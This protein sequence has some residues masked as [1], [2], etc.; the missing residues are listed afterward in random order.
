MW[1]SIY[2][3]SYSLHIFIYFNYYQMDSKVFTYKLVQSEN[4]SSKETWDIVI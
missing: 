4:L 1:Y 2:D 3:F